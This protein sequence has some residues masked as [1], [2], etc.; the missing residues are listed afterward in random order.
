[1]LSGEM[2]AALS[3]N[4]ILKDAVDLSVNAIDEAALIEGYNY[5][6]A[7]GVNEALFKVRVGKNLL[8]RT[9][10]QIQGKSLTMLTMTTVSQVMAALSGSM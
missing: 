6:I 2:I 1:M 3:Q 8:G 9:K 5:A 4:T 7:N 10:E